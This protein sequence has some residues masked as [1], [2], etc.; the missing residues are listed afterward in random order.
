MR[1]SSSSPA[2]PAGSSARY[3]SRTSVSV[4][5]FA[6][7]GEAA[8]TTSAARAAPRSGRK[9]FK[10]RA[11]PNPTMTDRDHCFPTKVVTDCA[12]SD[13]ENRAP[14]TE[15]AVPA[16]RFELA[17]VTFGVTVPGQPEPDTK[18]ETCWALEPLL[19]A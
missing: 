5:A 9:G 4:A 18:N 16:T 19:S 1:R 15:M 8:T 14:D 7:P 17:E 6:R 11:Y 12:A 10:P 2:Q 3:S 13:P